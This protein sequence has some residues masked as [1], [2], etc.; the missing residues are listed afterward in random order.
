MSKWFK[1]SETACK[2]GCGF[3]KQNVLLY[4]ILDQLREHFDAPV[5]ITSGNRCVTHNKKEGGAVRSQHLLGRAVDMKVKG[6]TPKRVYDYLD[7]LYPRT[8]GIKLYWNRIHFDVRSRKWRE[9]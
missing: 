6:V 3:D 5:T 9:E 1:T 7:Q 2:C 8:Y 4:A